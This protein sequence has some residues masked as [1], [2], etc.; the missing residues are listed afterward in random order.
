MDNLVKMDLKRD[1]AFRYGFIN[2]NLFN[3]V[4]ILVIFN[5][6]ENEIYERYEQNEIRCSLLRNVEKQLRDILRN[7]ATE[8]EALY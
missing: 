4:K 1:F 6:F 8:E 2:H 5:V 3:Y 7:L